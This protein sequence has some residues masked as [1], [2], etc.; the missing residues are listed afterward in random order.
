MVWE[1]RDRKKETEN[2]GEAFFVPGLC[3]ECAE[4]SYILIRQAL[5]VARSKY[6]IECHL[7]NSEIKL[8]MTYS[9][10]AEQL[11]GYLNV[12]KK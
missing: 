7:S 2:F 5:K 9:G 8:V 1:S 11:P 6:N 12:G 3:K 10:R 4:E